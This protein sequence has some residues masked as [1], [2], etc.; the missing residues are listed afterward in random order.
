MQEAI[1]LEGI[2]KTFGEKV[3]VDDFDLVVPQGRLYGFIGPNGAGKTT[4]IRMIMSILF[5]DRGRLTVL[6][7]PSAL[8]AKDRIGYLPEERGVY[9]KMKVAAFLEFIAQLKN[10]PR[11]DLRRRIM[12]WL[13]RV[14]LEDVAKKKC[15]ELSKGMQQKIQLLSSIIHE[16]DLLILDE[17]FSGLD[18]VNMRL[19]RDL[20]LEQHR[21]GATV[22]FS[23]HVMQQAE[24]LC[25]NI[26]MINNG[27][28]VLD[29]PLEEIRR[30]FDPRALILEPLEAD[31]DLAP[32]QELSCVERV[33]PS[34]QGVE[35]G[36]TEGTDPSAAIAAIAG[37]LPVARVEI[38]RPTLEEIFIEIVTGDRHASDE[39]ARTLR[40]ALQDPDRGGVR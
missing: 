33:K 24:Q 22:I 23:T 35:I 31:A 30:R 13:E 37:T 17:P 14:G 29:A 3:A 2:R 18:P 27:R 26:V 1:L 25:E 21:R 28:K 12:G 40:A 7:R 9:K 19:L 8:E 16:P 6:G 11:R 5:A 10:A 4:T 34:P 39:R 38:H 20:V 36:L 15:E 32:V